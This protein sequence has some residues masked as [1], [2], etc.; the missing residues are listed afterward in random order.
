[1]AI[2][3]NQVVAVTIVAE[4][5]LLSYLEISQHL[6]DTRTTDLDEPCLAGMDGCRVIPMLLV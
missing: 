5:L 1:M 4:E 2:L 6:A 3:L